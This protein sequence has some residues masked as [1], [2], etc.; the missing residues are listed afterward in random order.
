PHTIQPLTPLPEI[1]GPVTIDGG[2]GADCLGHPAVELDGS[3]VNASSNG[4][5]ISAGESIIRGLV[6]NRFP[7]AGL[8]GNGIL[9][10]SSGGDRIECSHIGTDADGTTALPN[11]YDGIQI[12]GSDANTIGG[13]TLLKTNV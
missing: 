11:D 10:Q 2:S 12:R 13:D 6:I 1:T 4:L 3:L 7:G 8:T 5:T 9:L